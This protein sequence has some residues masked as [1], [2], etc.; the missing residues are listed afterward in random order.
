MRTIIAGTRTF[1]DYKLIMRTMLTIECSVVVSGEAKGADK[2][3][4]RWAKNNNIPVEK[5]PA[6][7]EKHGRKA[8]FIRNCD[9]AREAD[10][11]VAFWDGTS[12]GTAHMIK[13]AKRKKLKVTVVTYE[14]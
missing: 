6:L 2:L 4:E 9:M 13:E 10:Q 14:A 5:H 12:K 1:D 3:G 8:G 7:W 11:L